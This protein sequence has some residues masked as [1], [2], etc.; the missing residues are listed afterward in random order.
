MF[1]HDS[2]L[3]CF[4]ISKCY[5]RL[6]HYR[7]LSHTNF[8]PY[9]TDL[10][11]FSYPLILSAAEL[12]T[13]CIHDVYMMCSE[14]GLRSLD[15]T[16]FTFYLFADYVKQN[17]WRMSDGNGLEMA[18]PVLRTATSVIS[19]ERDLAQKTKRLRQDW[20]RNC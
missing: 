11:E 2:L 16:Q 4:A 15:A 3:T 20:I 9:L 12:S 1:E 5:L 17:I 18:V 19:K 10:F 7:F 8:D 13:F 14:C 6:Y